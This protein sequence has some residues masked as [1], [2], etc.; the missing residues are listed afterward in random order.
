MEL[1]VTKDQVQSARRARRA[2]RWYPK[3]WRHRFGDEYVAL[4]EDE[5][6]EQPRSASRSVNVAW[7]GAMA[8][9]ADLGLAGGTLDSSNQIRAGAATSL[10]CGIFIVTASV[11]LWAPPTLSWYE[12]Q[13]HQQGWLIQ[14]STGLL[15]LAY[16]LMAAVVAIG[17]IGTLSSAF[18]RI[19]HG[20]GQG[21]KIS[22]AVMLAS[23]AYLEFAQQIA[24][25]YFV[26][27]GIEWAR[28][29]IAL[30]QLAAAE[31]RLFAIWES[32]A[33][34]T[35]SF[36]SLDGVVIA[37]A[38]LILT[39]FGIAAMNL[40]RRSAI[41]PRS[42]QLYRY[43]LVG[44]V[45]SIFA[46]IASYIVWRIAGGGVNPGPLT[47]AFPI[48]QLVL[49]GVLVLACSAALIQIGRTND[50]SLRNL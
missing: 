48:Y 36:S 25:R 20:R 35:R 46:C 50:R 9:L 19:I 14:L 45:A 18:W 23:A 41:S 12:G 2:L 24:L 16:G 34:S 49:V 13:N 43:V 40:I 38:P 22:A 21:L 17:L 39:I 37:L 28:P 15:T 44:F 47:L 27:G 30:Q 3:S 4:L 31:Y 8:R 29:G 32:A 7:K 42:G 1:D 10:F 6:L 11:K 33:T 26:P 5:F